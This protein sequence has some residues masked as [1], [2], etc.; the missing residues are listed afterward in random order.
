MQYILFIVNKLV[1]FLVHHKTASHPD[2][3]IGL[4]IVGDDIYGQHDERLCLHAGFLEIDHPETR[5]RIKFV[6]AKRKQKQSMYY[7]H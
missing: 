2:G 7:F 5:K 4:A 1:A 6:N 3:P